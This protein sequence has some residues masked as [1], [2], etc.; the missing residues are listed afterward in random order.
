M[1][2]AHRVAA[3]GVGLLTIVAAWMLL[4][5]ES[6]LAERL[7]APRPAGKSPLTEEERVVIREEIRVE[8]DARV[9]D[10]PVPVESLRS[11]VPT[12]APSTTTTT[13]VPSDALCP[14]WWVVA[15]G[16]GWPADPA[17]LKVLD[18][19][20][21]R[22]SR[23]L[24]HVIGNGGYGLTQI[25]WSVHREWITELGFERDEL[26]NP[27][28]NLAMARHLFLMVDDNAAFECG[29]SP[30]YPS[31]PGRSWCAVWEELS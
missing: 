5:S 14:Q 13:L 23:C 3:L 7:T 4:D 10:D 29:F 8:L 26:L 16:A 31:E 18:W 9:S 24:E 28:V 12:V 6:E 21:W 25:Q 17:L 11:T 27:A 2:V 15:T 22:E 19:I 20:M 1:S 30:W